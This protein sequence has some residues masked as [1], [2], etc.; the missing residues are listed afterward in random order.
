MS[1]AVQ[2]PTP[3]HPRSRFGE[4]SEPDA[5]DD[6]PGTGLPSHDL[7]GPERVAVAEQA[8]ASGFGL[9]ETVEASGLTPQVCWTIAVRLARPNALQIRHGEYERALQQAQHRAAQLQTA[10]A[11]VLNRLQ[12]LANRLEAEQLPRLSDRVLAI[13]VVLEDAAEASGDRK[14]GAV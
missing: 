5:C 13:V 4:R 6:H 8:V 7:V 3:L 12:R 14:G 9:D 1:V 10:M 2:V 11:G